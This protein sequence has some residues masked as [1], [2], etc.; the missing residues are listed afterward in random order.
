MKKL[1]AILLA[2]LMIVSFASCKDKDGDENDLDAYRQEEI[3]ID[4]YTNDKGQTFYFDSL[5]SESITITGYKGSDVPHAVEIPAEMHGKKVSGIS[6]Q[7]FYSLPTSPRS[8]FPTLLP[9]LAP[10]HLPSAD[11]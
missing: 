5:D 11:N 6:D 3:I 8:R 7:A 4:N 2:G 10:W 1:F 9:S